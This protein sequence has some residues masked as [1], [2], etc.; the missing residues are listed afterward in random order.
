MTAK[1]FWLV[2]R[3]GSQAGSVTT[4]Y[5]GSSGVLFYDPAP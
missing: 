5:Y 3:A 4:G 1:G 2:N